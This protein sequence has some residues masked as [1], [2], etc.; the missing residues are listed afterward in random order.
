M[1]TPT[2]IDSL[3]AAKGGIN[4]KIASSNFDGRSLSSA[5]QPKSFDGSFRSMVRSQGLQIEEGAGADQK[6]QHVHQKSGSEQEAS[7]ITLS[8]IEAKL[9]E[10]TKQLEAAKDTKGDLFQG[11]K[12]GEEP[13]PGIEAS[14]KSSAAEV[15]GN[16][17]DLTLSEV[18]TEIDSEFI[19][20]EIASLKRMLTSAVERS[21]ADLNPM[22]S[23]SQPVHSVPTDSLQ[24]VMTK[25]NEF[26]QKLSTDGS[27]TLSD[28]KSLY[29]EVSAKIQPQPHP[30][31]QSQITSKSETLYEEVVNPSPQKS[32]SADY[33]LASKQDS[34]L[35][36]QGKLSSG[37]FLPNFQLSQTLK[38]TDSG[39]VIAEPTGLRI[40]GSLNV[41]R[42]SSPAPSEWSPVV[43]NKNNADWNKELVSALGDRLKMQVGQGVKEATVR[44]DPPELGK[45]DFS[46]R[47]DGDKINVQINSGNTQVREMLA[48]QIDRL[49]NDLLSDASGSSVDVNVG[50]GK[51]GNENSEN[52]F[53]DNSNANTILSSD[54]E[55]NS[56]SDIYEKANKF[57]LNTK[58]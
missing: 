43:V 3:F 48:Q 57:G 30:V 1:K 52:T 44:L 16:L 22:A 11:V 54:N 28:L 46:V 10:I 25:L 56:K 20:E 7:N 53:A 6:L 49:R 17:E 4:K 29:K 40:D 51:S 19:V 35:S 24:L 31:P 18:R 15:A 39:Q 32:K 50:N 55:L 47:I 14:K 27:I 2:A 38:K 9:K 34:S 36:G 23:G 58:A 42:S 33:T 26:Q 8:D 21:S 37:D 13:P 12:G 5:D 45:V 41:Q